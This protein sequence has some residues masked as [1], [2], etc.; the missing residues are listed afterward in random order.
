MNSLI[1]LTKDK[2]NAIIGDSSFFVEAVIL[3]VK[4]KLVSYANLK[5]TDGSITQWKGYLQNSW[6]IATSIA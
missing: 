3:V 5:D 1:I 6:R 2:T 4:K